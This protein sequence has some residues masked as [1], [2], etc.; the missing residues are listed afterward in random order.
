MGKDAG[1]ILRDCQCGP[2]SAR[3]VQGDCFRSGPAGF[4]EAFLPAPRVLL[5]PCRTRN[6]S[7]A[8]GVCSFLKLRKARTRNREDISP[9]IIYVSRGLGGGGGRAGWFKESK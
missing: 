1:P 5:S 9:S 4:A 8:S 3:E 6:R 7:H 2:Q